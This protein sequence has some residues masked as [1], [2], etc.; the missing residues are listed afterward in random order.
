MKK[1][2]CVIVTVVSLG[3]F[4]IAADAITIENFPGGTAIT[5]ENTTKRT[6]VRTLD[7]KLKKATSASSSSSEED[8]D[9]SSDDSSSSVSVGDNEYKSLNLTEDD[10]IYL[11]RC[12]QNETSGRGDLTGNTKTSCAMNV[13]CV[14][15]NRVLSNSF[16]ST[17]YDVITQKSQFT[18]ASG[19]IASGSYS[20]NAMNAVKKVLEVGDITGGCLY[21]LNRSTASSVSWTN[22][23]TFMFTDDINHSFY[24]Q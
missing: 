23:L 22:N 8:P 17:V 16:P 10:L 2:V 15:L 11:A 20:D 14:I 9:T 24:K 19:Y 7:Y 21:F 13:A 12:V 6:S 1:R 4:S 3:L 18:G 5:V